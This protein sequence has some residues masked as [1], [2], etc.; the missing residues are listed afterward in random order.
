MLLGHKNMALPGARKELI[1]AP[2]PSVRSTP[3]TE[4]VA[5]PHRGRM[6]MAVEGRRH[7]PA[8][9]ARTRLRRDVQHHLAQP[10][11][12]LY[13]DWAAAQHAVAGA[14]HYFCS[15][16]NARWVHWSCKLRHG[17]YLDVT[18]VVSTFGLFITAIPVSL[19][20]DDC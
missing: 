20:T 11:P 3:A 2:T 6:Q 16:H 8:A 4:L 12:V 14:Q 19:A 18:R 10:D 1:P 15:E 7:A 5:E 13:T 17:S 9:H